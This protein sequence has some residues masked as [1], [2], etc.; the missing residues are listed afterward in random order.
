MDHHEKKLNHINITM[1]QRSGLDRNNVLRPTPGDPW[2]VEQHHW[3]PGAKENQQL[4]PG[5]PL[6]QVLCLNLGWLNVLVFYGPSTHFR[7][8]WARSVNL[9]TLFQGKPPSA[10][11]FAS[12][13]QL[14]FLNKRKGENGRS[15]SN[16]NERMWPDR[17][18]NQPWFAVRLA[19][20][21]AKQPGMS[22]SKMNMNFGVHQMKRLYKNELL[23]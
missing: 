10:H 5:G 17:R 16:L 21:Y 18:S 11:S 7:S 2:S 13:W 19:P 12:N 14:P 20:D 6:C 9:A 4:N 15:W 3:K 1:K 8:F 23:V 22:I